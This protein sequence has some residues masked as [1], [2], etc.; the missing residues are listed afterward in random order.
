MNGGAEADVVGGGLGNDTL[1]GADAGDSL[2][3]G[4]DNDVM[5]VTGTGVIAQGGGGN[6]TFNVNGSAHSLDGGADDDT[7]IINSFSTDLTAATISNIEHLRLLPSNEGAAVM[8]TAAQLNG[9]A[10]VASSHVNGTFSIN[11]ATTGSIGSNFAANSSGLLRGSAGGDTFNLAGTTGGWNVDAGEGSDTV[12][13]S[14]GNDTLGGGGGI[15]TASYS[16]SA[17]GVIVNLATGTGTG[18]DA[19]GDTLSGF[20]TVIGSGQADMLTGN[21]TDNVLTGNAGNDTLNG[22]AGA[23]TMIG[24]LGNDVFYIDHAGDIVTEALN[25]G[26]D[27]VRATVSKSLAA[28][29]ETLILDG[30]AHL[31]GAGNELANTLIGNSGNNVLDG[32]AGADRMFGHGG[33]DTYVVDNV[34]DLVGEVA[35]NGTDTV[36]ASISYTLG[37]QVENL[38][39]L[40]SANINGTGN[41]LANAIVG[42]TGSNRLDGAAG[43]DSLTGGLGLDY[44]TGGLGNDNFIYGAVA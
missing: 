5:N 24:G 39:L 20:E 41:A 27:I 37:N 3:G 43:N 13:G 33:N 14:A 44:L 30:T 22:G 1:N 18:G 23:D 12:H 28:N 2:D 42:N 8:L 16:G 35:G 11:M 4:N 32:R 25:Q 7:L 17:A 40:G 15:D 26:S 38:L 31:N 6:D 29:L 34:G 10:D 21:T 19:Q 9:F 36:K